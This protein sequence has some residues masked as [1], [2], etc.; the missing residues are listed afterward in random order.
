MYHLTP[1]NPDTSWKKKSSWLNSYHLMPHN[2]DTSW[3]KK[4]L[5]WDSN[6]RSLHLGTKTL[7]TWPLPNVP[8][9]ILKSCYNALKRNAYYITCRTRFIRPTPKRQTRG[10]GVVPRFFMLVQV[11]FSLLIGLAFLASL[12]GSIIKMKPTAPAP[13]DTAVSR[14]A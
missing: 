14:K 13:E 7:T 5:Q 1:H 10:R 4:I 6:L 2:P 11:A 9:K 8:I 12:E 3:K